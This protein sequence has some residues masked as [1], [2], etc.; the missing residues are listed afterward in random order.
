MERSAT[1]QTLE[2]DTLPGG[3][4][5][6]CRQLDKRVVLL[7]ASRKKNGV[8]PAKEDG[9]QLQGRAHSALILNGLYSWRTHAA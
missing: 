3:G 6:Y 1:S 8:F 7:G 2:V 5:V 4:D 9:L